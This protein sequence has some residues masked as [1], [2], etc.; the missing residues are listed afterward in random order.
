LQNDCAR[1]TAEKTDLEGQLAN[2]QT[3]LQQ[4]R[5]TADDLEQQIKTLRTELDER[6]QTN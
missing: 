4:A 2:T 3:E 1:L 5:Q 6:K